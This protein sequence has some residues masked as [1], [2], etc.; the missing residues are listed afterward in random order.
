MSAQSIDHAAASARS[1]DHAAASAERF[2]VVVIGSGPAGQKAAIQAVKAG[3]TVALL[4]RE[5]AIGGNCVHRGTIP[6]KTLRAAA[7]RATTPLDGAQLAP[8]IEVRSLTSQLESVVAAHADYMQR[9]MQRNGVAYLP[10]RAGFV[11]PHE[12]ALRSVDGSSRTLFGDLIVI[13]TGSRPREPREIP[14]DHENVLD[15]DSILSMI[16][17]PRSLTVLGAGVIA[18][19]YASIFARLGVDV[20][21]IDSGPRPLRF[22][23]GE[24]VDRFVAGF[25]RNGGRFIGGRKIASAAWDG[26][27]AVRTVLDDGSEVVSEKML[28]A[29]GRVANVEDLDLAAAGLAMDDRGQ[30]PADE[31]CRTAVP[32]I[33]AVGDVIGAPALA[34]TSM[35][36]GRR[37]ICHALGLPPG[38]AP[39]LSPIGI[40]TI[41]EIATVG[42]DEGQALE[43]HGAIIVGRARFDE[44]ARGQ[45]GGITDGLLKLVADGSGRLLLGAHIVGEGATELIHVAQMALLAGFGIDAFIENIFNF[46]TLAEAY[47]VAALDVAEQRQALAAAPP[48]ADRAA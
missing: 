10:G 18:C 8:N 32:H 11:S 40:Y 45:I 30:V 36:Q 14:I 23:D 20:T 42:L 41:P 38:H 24:I 6:S 28:V 48:A 26:I 44:V 16:Y 15:S 25:S 3:R 17:L 35:E 31:N 47:R 2:D 33:Y 46:P 43:R 34:S 1:I 9:Q 12:L 4:E 39:E 21:M 19:E 5:A 29:L 7:L 27:S 37:A 22:A 13:A